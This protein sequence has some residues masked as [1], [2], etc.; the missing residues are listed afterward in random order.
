MMSLFRKY[1]PAYEM[2]KK[3]YGRK[4]AKERKEA[5]KARF[6]RQLD[7][8]FQKAFPT[9]RAASATIPE[10][11][12]PQTQGPGFEA[13]PEA[14]YLAAD[15]LDAYHAD[16]EEDQIEAL[17]TP[18][19]LL[20]GLMACTDAVFDVLAEQVGAP[21]LPWLVTKLR[22]VKSKD[23]NWLIAVHILS[24]MLGV[25]HL[26]DNPLREDQKVIGPKNS[27]DVCT[28]LAGIISLSLIDTAV[29]AEEPPDLVFQDFLHVMR[30][31]S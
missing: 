18:G 16:R 14:V 20:A 26:V 9:Q 2:N 24:E 15:F 11:G 8:T 23:V 25:E 6:D 29:L 22:I 31:R 19:V 17:K 4:E 5:D 27:A 13:S 7:E 28:A 1:D 12:T 3:I 21:E 10:L 30:T